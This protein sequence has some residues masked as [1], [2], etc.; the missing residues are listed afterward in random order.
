M[1][2]FVLISLLQLCFTTSFKVNIPTVTKGT[3]LRT[4][5]KPSKKQNP[6]INSKSSNCPLITPLKASSSDDL[7]KSVTGEELEIML[8]DFEK[9]IVVDAYAT[10]CV[11]LC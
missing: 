5:L 11:F 7:A 3:R 6:F 4:F 8:T 10:W 1:S 2:F 9:P